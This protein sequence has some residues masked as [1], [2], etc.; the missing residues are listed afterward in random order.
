M[1]K[2]HFN[3]NNARTGKGQAYLY[4]YAP[5]LRCPGGARSCPLTS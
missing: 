1:V 4:Y 2:R 5:A 3:R